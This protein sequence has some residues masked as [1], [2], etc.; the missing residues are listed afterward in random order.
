MSD[1]SVSPGSDCDVLN[2]HLFAWKFAVIIWTTFCSSKHSLLS[3]IYND[4]SKHW[5][6]KKLFICWNTCNMTSGQTVSY[7]LT[8]LFHKETKVNCWPN[9]KPQTNTVLMNACS[10]TVVNVQR[11]A[12][13]TLVH[14]F[15][16]VAMIGRTF[17]ALPSRTQ[18]AWLLWKCYFLN[19]F[20][21]TFSHS[22]AY[23]IV[24]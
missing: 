5:A 19:I 20:W 18:W 15:L 8:W 4:L 13:V 17:A 22:L 9:P 11:K 12:S 14:E 1:N 23:L 3:E 2:H 24:F 21:S 7:K 10:C 16:Y 6:W